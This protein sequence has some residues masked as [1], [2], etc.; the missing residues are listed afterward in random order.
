MANPSPERSA[1]FGIFYTLCQGVAAAMPTP[2]WSTPQDVRRWVRGLLPML[3]ALCARTITV[4]DEAS[5]ATVRAI[6][7]DDLLWQAVWNDLHG[8]PGHSITMACRHA[9]RGTGS[10]DPLVVQAMVQTVREL[11]AAWRPR[12]AFAACWPQSDPQ[13]WSEPPE[14]RTRDDDGAEND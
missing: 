11:L 9:D 4:L 6:V 7:D 3:E 10:L 8:L 5:V 14:N 13:D 1:F 2:D 12:R